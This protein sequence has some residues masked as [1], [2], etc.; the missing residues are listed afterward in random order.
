[1]RHLSSSSLLFFLPLPPLFPSSP[2]FLPPSLI[3]S[4]E[5][6]VGP[7]FETA[8]YDCSPCLE[9][10]GGQVTTP[11]LC[12]LHHHYVILHHHD[13]VTS[14]G[15]WVVGVAK[16]GNSV[17]ESLIRGHSSQNETEIQ[18]Q[19][20]VSSY[21][22]TRIVTHFGDIILRKLHKWLQVYN[23]TSFRCAGTCSQQTEMI[24]S[25]YL[26]LHVLLICVATPGTVNNLK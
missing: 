9:L 1:V 15:L 18:I 10:I 8:P 11:T 17:P 2:F 26:L 20:P 13:V 16:R 6:G 25:E 14:P 12:Q 3:T 22:T 21:P 23:F 5:E 24:I 19:R 7:M 4:R